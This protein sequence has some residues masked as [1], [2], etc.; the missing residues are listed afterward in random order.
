MGVRIYII[1][2]TCGMGGKSIRPSSLSVDIK[3]ICMI[4]AA[5]FNRESKHNNISAGDFWDNGFG[6]CLFSTT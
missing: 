5:C 4:A 2:S 3:C 1:G 6:S